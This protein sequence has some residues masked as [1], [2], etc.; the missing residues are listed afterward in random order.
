MA[1]EFN[2]AEEFK[3]LDLAAVKKDLYALMTD[4][5]D[6]WPGTARVHTVQMTAAAARDQVTS[7]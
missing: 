5:Q 1:P 7:A 4:S 6:W 3:Q 2:Y